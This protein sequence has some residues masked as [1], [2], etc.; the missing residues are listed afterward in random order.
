VSIDY[1][2]LP[3]GTEVEITIKGTVKRKDSDDDSWVTKVDD[4]THFHH[5]C[6]YD[7]DDKNKNFTVKLT[8]PGYEIGQAYMDAE[9]EIFLRIE[10]GWL[11]ADADRWAHASAYVKRPL[12]KLVNPA[13]LQSLSETIAAI[14][15]VFDIPVS[16]LF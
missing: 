3:V 7:Y 12:T 1:E 16:L 14:C 4:G 9:G 6:F 10:N 5:V 15:R 11:D 2:N 13:E 8:E